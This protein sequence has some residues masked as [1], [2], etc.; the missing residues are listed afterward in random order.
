MWELLETGNWVVIEGARQVWEGLEE[1]FGL[2]LGIAGL[3]GSGGILAGPKC[4]VEFARLPN[5]GPTLP[6]PTLLTLFS[7]PV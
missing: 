1:S 7:R 3:V 6:L 5:F 4:R 2:A